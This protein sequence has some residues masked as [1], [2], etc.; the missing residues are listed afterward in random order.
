[1]T[2][3]IDRGATAKLGVA[4]LIAGVLIS[5]IIFVSTLIADDLTEALEDNCTMRCEG[6]G[7]E[8]ASFTVFGCDCQDGDG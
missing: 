6:R 7:Q 5:S 3:K 4:V 8:V 1:M 2:E